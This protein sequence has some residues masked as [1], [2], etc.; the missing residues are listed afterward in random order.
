VRGL[1]SPAKY[2]KSRSRNFLLRHTI[3][4]SF[5]SW[6]L[7]RTSE[8]QLSFEKRHFDIIEQ[9][10]RDPYRNKVLGRE[11]TK[12]GKNWMEE[13]GDHF[14]D[15]VRRWSLGLADTTY[16]F[17][18][19]EE[20]L[21]PFLSKSR[22]RLVVCKNRFYFWKDHVTHLLHVAVLCMERTRRIFV[23]SCHLSAQLPHSS[24]PL[25]AAAAA[26]SWNKRKSMLSLSRL[27]RPTYSNASL[28]SPRYN[29]T[30]L[31]VAARAESILCPRC[32]SAVVRSAC[33]I[34]ERI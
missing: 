16:R 15:G 29:A 34:L 27:F 17:V 11:M 8:N 31:G 5:Q 10:G 4:N 26:V 2:F 25:D 14:W 28:T 21:S 6:P 12:G 7:L 19:M 9:F 23:A 32:D 30:R 3:P 22:P 24:M 20:I 18:Y 1:S 13:V 33:S